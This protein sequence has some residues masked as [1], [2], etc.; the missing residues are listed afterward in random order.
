[1][2]PAFTFVA[3]VT[4]ALGIGAN[5]AIFSLVNTVLLRPFPVVRPDELYELSVF[6][7]HDSMLA[8]SY[9]DYVDFRYRNDVLSGLFVTRISPMSLSRNGSNEG[10][11]GYMVSGNYFDVLGVGAV[12]G[13]TFTMEDDRA[14]L[15]SPVVVLSYNCWQRRFGGDPSVVGQD[16]LINGHQFKIIGVAPKGFKGI[17]MIFTPEIWVPMMMQEWIERGIL[18]LDRRRTH[19]IFA[20]GRLKPGVSRGQAEA[21]LNVLAAA[22]GKEY[23]DTNEGATIRLIP[24]GFIIPSI[25]GAF[26]SLAA[27][28]M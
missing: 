8:F 9:P 10:L 11:W 14:K 6:G 12:L 18:W 5:T 19:N 25:R 15:A 16:V 4:L 24:P 1:K 28:L 3:I 2:R 7:K 21:S 17:E 20:T 26:I 23:P 13:G 27:I 22:L